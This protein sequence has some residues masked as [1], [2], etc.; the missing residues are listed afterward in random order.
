MHA[1]LVGTYTALASSITGRYVLANADSST[2][3]PAE[4]Y[5]SVW[6]A[7]HAS[8]PAASTHVCQNAHHVTETA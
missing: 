6:V 4:R 3:V 7:Q 5:L 1:P 8:T 2:H